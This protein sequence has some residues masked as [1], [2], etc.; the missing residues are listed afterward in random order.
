MARGWRCCSI[1]EM[2][3]GM[4]ETLGFSPN[5]AKARHSITD[6]QAYHWGSEDRRIRGSKPGWDT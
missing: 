6:L 4:S 3:D 2:L 1:G 5:T